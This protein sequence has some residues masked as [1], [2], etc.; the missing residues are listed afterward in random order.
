MLFR[1]VFHRGQALIP[2]LQAGAEPGLVHQ[3]G[4]EG[5]QP[6]GGLLQPAHP[7][8]RLVRGLEPDPGGA[9]GVQAHPPA[10]DGGR[11]GVA[12]AVVGGP[13]H[14]QNLKPTPTLKRQLEVK[15]WLA[16][17]SRRGPTGV[18]TITPV[19]TEKP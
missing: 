13:D 5:L 14:G 4:V 11:N 7:E 18:V 12:T 3:S 10:F 17:S 8:P 1:S 9:A 2:Q 6:E 19:P 16:T 15:S